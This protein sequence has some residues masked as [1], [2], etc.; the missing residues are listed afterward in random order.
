MTNG[1]V[2][3]PHSLF[4]AHLDVYE[5]FM[6]IYLMDCENRFQKNGGWM[7][8]TNED[9]FK[10]G[11]GRDRTILSRA[12]DGLT[13]RGLIE[14]NKGHKGQR[15]EYRINNNIEET[16]YIMN[17]LSEEANNFI[18]SC[19]KDWVKYLNLIRRA[20]MYGDDECIERANNIIV[21]HCRDWGIDADSGLWKEIEEYIQIITRKNEE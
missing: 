5:K 21:P 1:Y 20:K 7:T 8:L 18:E 6:L 12:R 4:E 13:S 15:S 19:G 9:F 17:K 11:F 16:F 14:Y 2:Q 3:I 10:V